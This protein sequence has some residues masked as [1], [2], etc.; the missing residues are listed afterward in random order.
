LLEAGARA[1]VATHWAIG[2]QSILPLVDRFYSHMA[3][4]RNV[5]S[6]LRSAKLDAIREKVSPSVWAAFTLV[7]DGNMQ[8]K[9]RP[10][11]SA[12]LQWAQGN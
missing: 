1:V 4:G 10:I 5:A 7:G 8:V 9:L 3:A 6:S 2:D 11:A 12:P